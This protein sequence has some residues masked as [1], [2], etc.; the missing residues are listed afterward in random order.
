MLP[1]PTIDFVCGR[2][3]EH[4]GYVYPGFT[5]AD[6]QNEAALGASPGHGGDTYVVITVKV[7][8]L[9]V[10]WPRR[11]SR[12]MSPVIR[13]SFELDVTHVKSAD[14]EL[15]RRFHAFTPS[16]RPKSA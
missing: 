4:D 16:W 5:R 2:M 12:V 15:A 13:P 7:S 10:S 9:C 3:V 11:I 8:R 14:P 6:V 1:S